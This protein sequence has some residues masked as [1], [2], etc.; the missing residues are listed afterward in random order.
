MRLPLRCLFASLCWKSDVLQLEYKKEPL[1][2]GIP[3]GHNLPHR[4]QTRPAVPFWCPIPGSDHESQ[5]GEAYMLTSDHV[6]GSGPDPGTYLARSSL[7]LP[8]P[9]PPAV[10]LAH[11][12]SDAAPYDV[13][14]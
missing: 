4:A 8:G 13:P 3:D 14:Q 11:A 10:D 6:H 5:Q 1:S 7:F 2:Q 9:H 12:L